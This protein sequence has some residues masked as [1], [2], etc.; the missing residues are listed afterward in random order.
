MI[1]RHLLVFGAMLLLSSPV[2]L[3]AQDKNLAWAVARAPADAF[4]VISTGN[5]QDLVNNTRKLTGRADNVPDLSAEMEKLLPAGI[6]VKGAAVMV[7][8]QGKRHPDTVVLICR[9]KDGASLEGEPLEDGIVKSGVASGPDIYLLKMSPWAAISDNLAAVKAISASAARLKISPQQRAD[10]N[11]HSMWA[12]INT[13]A[14]AAAV[15]SSLPENQSEVS[16]SARKPEL[17]G[18]AAWFAAAL[19]QVDSLTAVIDMKPE[20]AS[21]AIGL[22]YTPG[23]QLSLLAASAMPIASYKAGLPV[24]DRILIAGWGRI[25]WLKAIGPAKSTF[26]P[27]LDAIVPASNVNA[28]KSLDDLWAVYDEWAAAV[29]DELGFVLEPAPASEGMYRMTETISVKNPDT[30]RKLIVKTMPLSANLTKAFT[31]LGPMRGM[32][33]QEDYKP[34]AENIEGIPVDINKTR[35]VFSSSPDMSPDKREGSQKVLDAL[36]GPEGLTMRMAVVG[37][38]AV[39]SMGGKAAMA[40]AIS[41]V[42]GK[43]PDLSD[44]PKVAAALSRVPKNASFAGLISLPNYAHFTISSMERMMAATMPVGTMPPPLKEPVSGDLVTL[45][46]HAQ[47]STQYFNLYVPQSEIRGMIEIFDQMPSRMGRGRRP[48]NGGGTRKIS[49]APDGQPPPGD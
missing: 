45:S 11:D 28:R 15:K 23:S 49:P 21:V 17:T 47:A 22:E 7:I 41:S 14:L 20:A 40:R 36:Y 16:R 26:R 43:A 1:T 5:V 30:F 35:V 37:R 42:Q 10:I 34:A 44:N 3:R 12:W 38:T 27:L 39:I 46:A 31:D 19:D 4:A 25:D 6:D 33:V 24:S 32:E 48:A 13:K 9:I 18:V 29:G 2:G 8:M